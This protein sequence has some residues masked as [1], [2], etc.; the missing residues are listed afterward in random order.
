MPL[1]VLIGRDGSRGLEL[2][3]KHRDAHLANLRP[4]ADAKRVRYPGPRLD[5]SGKPCGSLVIFEAEDL[6]AARRFVET[7]PY[8]VEGVFQRYEVLTT[9][10]VFPEESG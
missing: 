4:R 7:D 9:R 10:S 1:F 8:V 6:A 5:D 3:L 2:R